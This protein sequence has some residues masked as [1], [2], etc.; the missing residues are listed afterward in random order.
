MCTV[1]PSANHP[2]RILSWF[3]FS[4]RFPFW[5]VK[6][7]SPVW[8][9]YFSLNL[10]PN[11]SLCLRESQISPQRWRLQVV[12]FLRHLYLSLYKNFCV[13]VHA[14]FVEYTFTVILLCCL[15][16]I[17]L[18]PIKQCYCAA[19]SIWNLPPSVSVSVWLP[20]FVRYTLTRHT[21]TNKPRE[22]IALAPWVLTL[23]I[24]HPNYN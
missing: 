24:C 11:L 4:Y 1:K 13:C 16:V 9:S 7:N 10:I 14:S 12:C 22:W 6:V 15:T 21:T 3:H 18:S 19:A 5:A 17:F 8:S 20:V 2:L 23:A